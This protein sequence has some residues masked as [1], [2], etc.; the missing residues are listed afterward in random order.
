MFPPTI[1]AVEDDLG[2]LESYQ[3]L[4]Q[5][6]YDLITAETGAEALEVLLTRSINLIILDI[7]LPD[8]SGIDILRKAK[9]IDDRIEVIMVSGVGE[10]KIAVEAMKLGAYD[11]TLKPVEI[12]ELISNY[13]LVPF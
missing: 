13:C 11:Y 3:V 4:L 2:M 7:L 6:E 10:V 1:L 9:S 5:D 12:E 8:I